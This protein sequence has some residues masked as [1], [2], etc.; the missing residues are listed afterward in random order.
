V[1]SVSGLRLVR[2]FAPSSAH[3]PPTDRPAR[4]STI[5]T[6]QETAHH[7]KPL[8]FLCLNHA[9]PFGTLSRLFPRSNRSPPNPRFRVNPHRYRT[10]P[11]PHDH[12][13]ALRFHTTLIDSPVGKLSVYFGRFMHCHA[14]FEPWFCAYRGF[15]QPTVFCAALSILKFWSGSSFRVG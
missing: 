6:R 15:D 7:S 11:S 10:S 5:T 14:A 9:L 13:Q 2:S 3:L 12:A 8:L 1:P 4:P